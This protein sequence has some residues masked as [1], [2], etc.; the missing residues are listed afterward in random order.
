M[1]NGVKWVRAAG[2][3]SSGQGDGGSDRPALRQRAELT[4]AVDASN[5]RRADELLA[6]GPKTDRNDPRYLAPGDLLALAAR[7]TNA[8]MVQLL[9]RHAGN[10]M[11]NCVRPAACLDEEGSRLTTGRVVMAGGRD[12]AAD[13]GAPRGRR[14]AGLPGDQ[15][16]LGSQGPGEA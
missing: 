7:T 8:A 2:L 3:R 14:G 6:T 15:G 5:V 1:E 16:G 4:S 11:D 9:V 10:D 13:G 12:A